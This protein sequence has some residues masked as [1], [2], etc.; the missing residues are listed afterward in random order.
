[1]LK[2]DK[3]KNTDL[4]KRAMVESS[5]EQKKVRKNTSLQGIQT[6]LHRAAGGWPRDGVGGGVGVAVC[7]L[8]EQP[9][10]YSC[11]EEQY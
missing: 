7:L 4:P 10:R 2:W 11:R 1:M 6:A 8:P 9:L 5:Q 3:G